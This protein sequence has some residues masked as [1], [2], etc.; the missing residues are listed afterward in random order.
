ME[1][2]DTELIVKLISQNRTDNVIGLNDKKK[3]K[4]NHT[5]VYKTHHR[6]LR[7]EEHKIQGLS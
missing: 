6:K 5:A 2:E 7:S 3:S 4:K 1:A